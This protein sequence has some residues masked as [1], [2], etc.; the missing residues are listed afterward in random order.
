MVLS[1]T[2]NEMAT[3]IHFYV[4]NLSAFVNFCVEFNSV[5][6]Q[7]A[8][9]INAAMNLDFH[10][11]KEFCLSFLRAY[12]LRQNY[13]LLRDLGMLPP[14][15]SPS[16]LKGACDIEVPSW[17][18]DA[19]RE[20]C[21][22]HIFDHHVYFPEIPIVSDDLVGR[23]VSN[24]ATVTGRPT[25]NQGIIGPASNVHVAL[26]IYIRVGFYRA[27][28]ATFRGFEFVGV[29]GQECLEF[30]PLIINYYVLKADLAEGRRLF[31]MSEQFEDG[32]DVDFADF[33]WE[34]TYLF[35]IDTDERRLKA[36]ELLQFIVV[37]RTDVV[38]DT[39][40]NLGV[41]ASQFVAP[42]PVMDWAGL[43]YWLLN[44]MTQY[45]GGEYSPVFCKIIWFNSLVDSYE[46]WNFP[47]L[48]SVDFEKYVLASIGIKPIKSKRK[49]RKPRNLKGQA[50]RVDRKVEVHESE[51]AVY[52]QR[53]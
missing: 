13:E 29:K 26:G 19:C 20:Y 16:K 49:K 6:V 14:G 45:S 23:Q 52:Q 47:S 32:K 36:N 2:G 17:L 12:Y 40:R 9:T 18:L 22:G 42:A 31:Y 39:C 35:D 15:V 7:S 38:N 44:F 10:D 33:E 50:H 11:F 43:Q 30:M 51:P 25:R 41:E 34:S 53:K 21:R 28:K 48:G 3:G 24:H 37:L 8:Y 1:K 5:F 46:R 27:F 4:G